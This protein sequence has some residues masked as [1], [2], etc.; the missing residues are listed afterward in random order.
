M[1][2]LTEK[3]WKNKCAGYPWNVHPVKHIDDLPYYK[4][5]A[6]YEDLEEQGRLIVLSVEDIHPCRNCNTGWGSLSSDGVSK[7]CHDTCKKLNKYNEK[8][9]I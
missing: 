6:Y 8:Y 7:S 5:L 3:D 1:K 9:N 4:K 2:R